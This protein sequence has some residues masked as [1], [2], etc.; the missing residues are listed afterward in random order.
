MRL[1]RLQPETGQPVVV[2]QHE[3]VYTL[4]SGSLEADFTDTGE[5]V[6]GQLLA[7][8]QPTDIFCIG[9]N[10]RHHAAEANLEIPDYPVLFMKATSS[11]QHPGQPIILPRK[12]P[13]NRVDFEA[14]L[15]G[16]AS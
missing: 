12:M 9:L 15:R 1:A 2:V 13:S 5:P 7:P 11:I 14:E 4:A 3:D 8:V 6:T 16:I 10:Y